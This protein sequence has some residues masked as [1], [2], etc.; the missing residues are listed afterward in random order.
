M[1]DPITIFLD[2]PVPTESGWYVIATQHGEVFLV[3]FVR[4][5]SGWLHFQHSSFGFVDADQFPC[6]KFSRRIQIEGASP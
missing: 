6:A 1:N 5:E 2:G 4:S 3:K